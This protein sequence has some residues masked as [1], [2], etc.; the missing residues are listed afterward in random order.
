MRG[1]MQLGRVGGIGVY[2]HWTFLL[3]VGWFAIMFLQAGGMPAAIRG[4]LLLL[5]IF[6]CVVLHELGHAF[7]ARRFGVTTRDITLYPIGGVSRLE[8]IPENP[9][10]ELLIAL[11]GPAVNFVIAGVLAIV[12][13]AMGAFSPWESVAS[14]TGPFLQQLLW[15]NVIIGVF[16]LLPAF[17]MD[18]GRVLRSLLA[19]RMDYTLA[20]EAAARV[21]QVIAIGFGILGLLAFNVLLI[22]IALFVYLGAQAEAHSA[23]IRSV[24]HGVPVRAAM[25]TQFDRLDAHQTLGEAADKIVAGSQ[26]DFPVFEDGAFAGVLYRQDLISKLAD[27]ERGAPISVALRRE[28]P[29]VPD[30]AMLQDVFAQMQQ[31]RL[32]M[33][34]V[35]RGGEIVGLITLE[36]VG[37]WVMIQSATRHRQPKGPVGTARALPNQ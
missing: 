15:F 20:T 21:G 35:T 26:Q 9:T 23:M 12:V 1:A 7:T 3:L 13:L 14:V 17:P 18:G 25:I 16:N 5:S 28:V 27:T 31:N 24:V 2:V 37:E 10:H 22:F 36:N 29:T 33:V 30:N 11:A 19:R 6:G 34:P 32:P 4:V 8:R